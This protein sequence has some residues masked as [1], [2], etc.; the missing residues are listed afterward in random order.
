MDVKLSHRSVTIGNNQTNLDPDVFVHCD[1]PE[2]EP[3]VGQVHSVFVLHGHVA[4]YT[5]NVGGSAVLHHR[6]HLDPNCI[7]VSARVP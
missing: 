3:I 6:L 7:H 1:R 4:A 2:P 5:S